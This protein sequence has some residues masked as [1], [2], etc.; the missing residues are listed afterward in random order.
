MTMKVV[1]LTIPLGQATLPHTPVQVWERG[2]LS[3]PYGM[4]TLYREVER[5]LSL[6]LSW[7]RGLLSKPYGTSTLYREVERFHS[8]PLSWERG[9]HLQRL[10]LFSTLV[11]KTSLMYD[12]FITENVKNLGKIVKY[13]NSTNDT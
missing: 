6:P 11:D 5:F 1:L 2:L 4:S 8:L 7:E 9:P 12:F 10:A 3:K 13:S